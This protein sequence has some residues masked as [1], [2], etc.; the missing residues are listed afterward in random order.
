M[1]GKFLD[2]DFKKVEEMMTTLAAKVSAPSDDIY[3]RIAAE[4]LGIPKEQVTPEQRKAAKA[5]CWWLLYTTK[6]K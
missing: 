5:T 2:V 6:G 3:R 4:A 1:S